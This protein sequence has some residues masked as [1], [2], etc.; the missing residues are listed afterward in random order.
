[1]AKKNMLSKMKERILFEMNKTLLP[2]DLGYS[3]GIVNNYKIVEKMSV[4]DLIKHT[5]RISE[6]YKKQA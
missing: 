3:I 2:C 5:F 6:K 4:I 1:M